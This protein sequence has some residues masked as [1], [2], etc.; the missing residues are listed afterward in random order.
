[1]LVKWTSE[2]L[3]HQSGGEMIQTIQFKQRPHTMVKPACCSKMSA[4]Y[5]DDSTTKPKGRFMTLYQ[6]YCR[7]TDQ[8]FV[9]RTCHLF[10]VT[11][12]GI[13]AGVGRVRSVAS[14]CLSVCP[15]CNR[16]TVWAI[17]TKLGTRILYSSR[18]ASR[19]AL[20]QWSKGQRSR[21]HG[22]ENTRL[23]GC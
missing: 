14:V 5:V 10:I 12:A 13:T 4:L 23:H 16:T 17:N 22:Y 21:S 20:T 8:R 7:W 11:H 9:R 1:M 3:F 15:R 18:S 2:R 6:G 19:H